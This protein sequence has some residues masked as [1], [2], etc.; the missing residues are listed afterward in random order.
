MTNEKWF[1]HVVRVR[2]QETDQMG[3]VY[4]SNYLTWFEIGRTELIRA[5]GKPYTDF[6]RAGL[7]LPVL[8]INAQFKQPARYDDVIAIYTKVSELSSLRISFDVEV[9]RWSEEDALKNEGE[10]IFLSQ[11]TDLRNGELLVSGTTRHVWVNM[12]WKPVRMD[13]S[14]PELYNLLNDSIS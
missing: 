6:E 9:R 2:Y 7:L 3:V 8:E 5:L 14:F 11:K 1:R 13:K 10:A 4:H 12:E